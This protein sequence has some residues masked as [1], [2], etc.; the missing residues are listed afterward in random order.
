MTNKELLENLAF[1]FLYYKTFEFKTEED[2]QYAYNTY[3]EYK[4]EAMKR[5]NGE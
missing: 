5:M 1:A 3:K 4:T 2:K